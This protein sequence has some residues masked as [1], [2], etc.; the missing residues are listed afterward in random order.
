MEG[1]TIMTAAE[2]R[3]Q[4]LPTASVGRC[5]QQKDYY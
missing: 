2:L 3:Q 4:Y 5:S 1:P